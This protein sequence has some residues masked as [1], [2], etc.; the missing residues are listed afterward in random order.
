MFKNE[1]AEL[2]EWGFDMKPFGFNVENGY[3]FAPDVG[4]EQGSL[5]ERSPIT[6]PACGH[7]FVPER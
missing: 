6:C 2:S 3:D 7:E 1:L 5:D 4:A